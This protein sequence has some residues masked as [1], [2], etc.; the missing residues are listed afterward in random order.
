MMFEVEVDGIRFI[1]PDDWQ[2]E[3]YDEWSF[4][5]NR[6]CS[7]FPGRKAVDLLA[8]SP[9]NTLFIVEVKD[10]RLH[11]RVKTIDIIDEVTVKVVDTLSALMPI[12]LCNN[13]PNER[14]FARNALSCLKIRVVLHLE[15]AAPG[16]RNSPPKYNLPNV[17][18]KMQQKLKD[19]DKRCQASAIAH[20]QSLDWTCI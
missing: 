13:F 12:S 11:R 14:D 5:R 1:F 10:Y 8:I 2:A 9:D 4:Y 3:K 20:M 6:F 7:V 17:Q 18:L 16:N 15:Q 19:V